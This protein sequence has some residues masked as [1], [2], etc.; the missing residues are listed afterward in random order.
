M[1]EV[2]VGLLPALA[3]DSLSEALLVQVKVV[4][5]LQTYNLGAGQ[6]HCLSMCLQVI[7]NMVHRV[8]M[9]G[10]LDFHHQVFLLQD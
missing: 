1:V 7:E 9:H 5:R 10:D 4:P 2:P 6:L 8:G 3:S